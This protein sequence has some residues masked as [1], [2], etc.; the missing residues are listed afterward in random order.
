MQEHV[1]SGTYIC[2]ILR[3]FVAYLLAKAQVS[4]KNRNLP[5]PMLQNLGLGAYA[6]AIKN[7]KTDL[8]WL[9]YDEENVRK[10]IEDPWCGHENTGGFWLEFLRGMTTIWNSSALN[11][12]SNDERIL[13]I[14]G[15]D[16]PVGRNGEGLRWLKNTYEK[17]GVRQTKLILYPHMRHEILN[18]A[19]RETVFRD[20]LD[21]IG[22]CS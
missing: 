22:S 11:R 1:G 3:H 4:D 18:E 19:G 12:I 10:Y 15:E 9:S 5:S 6:K 13:I 17:H 16:D 21:F 7:R 20:I 8:D 2:C 14:G